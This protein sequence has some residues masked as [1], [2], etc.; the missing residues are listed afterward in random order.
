[1][2]S[3]SIIETEV[4]DFMNKLLKEGCFDSFEVREVDICSFARF[5]IGGVMP[6]E[7][8]EDGKDSLCYCTWGELRPYVF[9]IIKGR[10]PRAFKIVLSLPAEQAAMLHSNM[11]ACFINL[12]FDGS[13]VTCTASASEKI[14][15]LDR[16]AE[17]I[18]NEY[19][20]KFFKENKILAKRD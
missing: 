8:D 1:M 7:A 4:R 12:K 2:L 16:T 17:G 11:S 5:V 20:Q 18:W 10:R 6:E 19:I 9:N 14:F 13:R 3:F 15:V